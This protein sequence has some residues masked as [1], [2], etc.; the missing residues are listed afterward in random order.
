MKVELYL[1]LGSDMGDR[2]KN[3]GDAISCLNTALGRHYKSLSSVI[4]TEPWG[5][6]SETMFLNAAVMYELEFRDGYNPEAEGLLLLEKC[7]EIE[8]LFGRKV[9]ECH[10]E[11]GER[12]YSSRPIDIDI[13]FI[14]DSRIDCPELTVPHRLMKERDFVMVPLR[15]IASDHIRSVFKD[16]F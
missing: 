13:L 15:E 2:A 4:E 5:F 11:A 12:V 10:N 9:Q 3:I 8:S 14:G 7:K 6:E 1:S 16:I